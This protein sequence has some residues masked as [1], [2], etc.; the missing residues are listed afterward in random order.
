MSS[1]IFKN[2]FHKVQTDCTNTAHH[3]LQLEQHGIAKNL[4]CAILLLGATVAV[5]LA[6][7]RFP[8]RNAIFISFTFIC[9][10]VIIIL[11]ETGNT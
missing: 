1:F 4:R 8:L 10:Y 11:K 2:I 9:I 7:Y 5:F 6:I 3:I